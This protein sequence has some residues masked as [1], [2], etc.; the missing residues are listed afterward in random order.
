LNLEY[1]ATEMVVASK[2]SPTTC[3]TA[4]GKS[5]AL[6]WVT[7]DFKPKQPINGVGHCIAISFPHLIRTGTSAVRYDTGHPPL[8]KNGYSTARFP[9]SQAPLMLR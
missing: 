8:Q 3:A 7:N 5:R 9:A 2:T 6:I 4:A 1:G